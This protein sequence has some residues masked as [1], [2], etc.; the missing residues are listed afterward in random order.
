MLP[1]S[2]ITHRTRKR[3]RIKIPRKRG[4]AIYFQTLKDKLERFH[5][6]ETVQA[7]SLTGS[8]LIITHHAE[9][10]DIIS[11]AE[12]EKL[13]TST[14]RHAKSLSLSRQL[15]DPLTTFSDSMKRFSDGYVDLPGL[16][17][18]LLIGG[19]IYQVLKGN[20]VIPPWYT[21]FWYGFGVFTK[22]VMDHCEI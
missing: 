13:F 22:T 8:L 17:F 14:R 10:D 4:D 16:I 5:L 12:S 2:Y 1:Q 21:F 18:L 15:V 11:F 9:I 19:G 20:L 6:V 3:V 7:N